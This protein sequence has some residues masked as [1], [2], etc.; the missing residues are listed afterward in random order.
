MAGGLADVLFSFYDRRMMDQ[1]DPTHIPQARRKGRGALSNRDS[2]FEPYQHEAVDDGWGR[3]EDLP[4]LRTEV[5]QESP[6]RIIT[7]TTSTA[8][9]TTPC[10]GT[11][12]P[13]P[14]PR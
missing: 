1:Q 2:R 8:N 3:D 13:P 4:P 7:K 5:A 12:T 14:K 10:P 9:I 11:V 6:R